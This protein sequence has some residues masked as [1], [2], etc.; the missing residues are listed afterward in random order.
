[1]TGGGERILLVGMMGAGKTTIGR[2]LGARLG[3]PFLDNDRLVRGLTGRE[4]AE[5]DATDGEDALHEAEIAAFHAAVAEPGPAIIAVAGAVVDVPTERARLRDAGVV[6]WLRARPETLRAR[7]GSGAGR[8]DEATD[9]AWIARRAAER[10]P[11]YAE[12]ADVIVDVDAAG[13]E[14]TAA[15]ILERLADAGPPPSPRGPVA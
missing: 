8:R 3:R 15:R 7:I 6:V 13:A 1:V 10:E 4:P 9:L 14:E 12:V 11:A 2:E 5:I